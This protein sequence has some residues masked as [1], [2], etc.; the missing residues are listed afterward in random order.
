[1]ATFGIFEK[2]PTL[3]GIFH[4]SVIPA[5]LIATGL[6]LLS[7]GGGSSSPPIVTPTNPP[8]ITSISPNSVSAGSNGFT[9]TVNGTNFNSSSIV[10]WSGSARSTEYVG[11]TQLNAIIPASD[12]S[13][14]GTRV[15]TVRNTSPALATSNGVSFDINFPM[16]IIT[17]LYPSSIPAESEDFTLII[18]GRNFIPNSTLQW[19]SFIL[20]GDF[21]NSTQM[22]FN[23]GSAYISS[24]GIVDIRVSNP[25]PG[26]GPSN[27]LPFTVKASGLSVLTRQLPD[28]YNSKPYSY[29]LQAEGGIVPYTWSIS[30]GSLPNGLT[31]NPEG[32]ISGTAPNVAEDTSYAFTIDLDDASQPAGT[33][34]V[35][36]DLRI[37]VKSGILGRNDECG[38]P[39]AAPTPISNGI[40]RASIS[41]YGD[42]D[43][44]T[45]QGT[46]GSS[47]TVE[48]SAQRIDIDADPTSRDIYLDSFLE[49]LDE[50]CNSIANND[51]I[52]PGIVNDSLISNYVLPYDGTYY[53]RVS[54]LRG[55]GRPD[56]IY[57]LSLSGAD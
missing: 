19:G 16:P 34:R 32:E 3:S 57:D 14:G 48:I 43:V 27:T 24:E 52:D 49:I 40:L 4:H 11:S 10:Q 30:G 13:A 1:M 37:I 9:L 6:F 7:C 42:I 36:Q 17:L 33:H 53:I 25:S 12:V 51:D 23:I 50:D 35:S 47:I 38:V 55:D 44:Y 15:I 39:T 8:S 20:Y 31:L 56:F 18:Y 22:S 54:D 5:I 41:P 29:I 46:Q 21:V 45:F 2:H 28:A 26:G